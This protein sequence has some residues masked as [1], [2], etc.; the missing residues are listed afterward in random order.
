MK[1]AMWI[2]ITIIAVGGIVTA[3]QALAKFTAG[4][5]LIQLY[6]GL[7]PIKVKFHY[8]VSVKIMQHL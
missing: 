1:K 5:K 3:E 2:P 6:S 4:A 7:I 8:A